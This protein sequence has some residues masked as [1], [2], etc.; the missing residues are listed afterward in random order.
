MAES[1]KISTHEFMFEQ[2]RLV[3]YGTPSN[4][5]EGVITKSIDLTSDVY[6]YGQYYVTAVV[7]DT[8][9]CS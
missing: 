6:S 8:M 5:K 3:T 7:L 4:L 9:V 2:H 1:F